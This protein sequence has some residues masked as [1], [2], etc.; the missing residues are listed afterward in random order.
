[1]AYAIENERTSLCAR[2]S[3]YSDRLLGR[4]AIYL[5]RTKNDRSALLCFYLYAFRFEN[6]L[7]FLIAFKLQKQPAFF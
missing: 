3:E 2:L 5:C 1:M 7:Q 6:S 4:V